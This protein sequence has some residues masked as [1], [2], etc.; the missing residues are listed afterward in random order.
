MR[1]GVTRLVAA[2]ALAV[3][4]VSALAQEPLSYP[5]TRKSDHVDTYHGVKV[6]DPYRWLEDDNSAE[7]AAWVEAQNKVT[8]GYLER[9]PYRRALAAR[10]RAL[11]DYERYSAPSRK[12]QY[13]FFR[14][15]DGLQDQSVL[16]I[17]KGFESSPEVLIPR[18]RPTAATRSRARRSSSAPASTT[19]PATSSTSCWRGCRTRRPA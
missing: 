15:N 10:L 2:V 19:S 7:T 11:N 13:V 1:I 16:Y 18:R 9:I 12:A 17:Q 8:F 4:S 3:L 14:K 5:Q 6:A